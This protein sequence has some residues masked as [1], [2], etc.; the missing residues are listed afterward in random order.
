VALRV[1]NTLQVCALFIAGY[2]W[3]RA[4]NCNAVAVGAGSALIALLLVGVT[5]ALGG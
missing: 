1:S 3:G 2:S 4:T 5:V